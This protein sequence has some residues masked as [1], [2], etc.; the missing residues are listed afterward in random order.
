MFLLSCILLLFS[1]ELY[2]F[3]EVLSTENTSINVSQA[4]NF[5]HIEFKK[6]GIK[7]TKYNFDKSSDSLLAEVDSSS[8]FLIMP[9]DNSIFTN[10]VQFQWK[11]ESGDLKV[12]NLE[13]EQSNDG[14]DFYLRVGLVLKT[15]SQKMAIQDSAWWKQWPSL[16]SLMGR[17]WHETLIDSFAAKGNDLR[18]GIMLV[19]GAQTPANSTWTTGFPGLLMASVGSTN[20][21]NSNWM[22]AEIDLRKLRNR[23][24]LK[25]WCPSFSSQGCEIIGLWIMSDGDNT[26]S[27]FTSHLKEIQLNLIE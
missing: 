17:E 19:P 26:N 12:N 13:H 5:V 27:M 16:A 3:S 15:D 1:V 21:Q 14:D 23:D 9:F 18:R 2:S 10:H 20:N 25:E 6:K 4:E 22:S 8:S 7:P 24:Q 11:N